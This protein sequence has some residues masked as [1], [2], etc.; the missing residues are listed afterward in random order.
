LLLKPSKVEVAVL[1]DRKHKSFPIHVDYVGMS[2]ATT[3]HENIVV[4]LI[5]VEEFEVHLQ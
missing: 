5:D 1:M 3:I 2:L 4:N